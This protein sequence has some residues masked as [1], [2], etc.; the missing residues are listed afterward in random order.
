MNYA[1]TEQLV[2]I[3]F[4]LV[5]MVV[6]V[7]AAY[8]IVP[9]VKDSVIPWLQDRRLYDLIK[10]YVQAAEKMASSNIITKEDKKQFV[11][12]LLASRGVQV[13]AEVSAL[14]ESAVKELDI[15][16]KDGIDAVVD[17]FLDEVNENLDT[18]DVMD[19]EGGD[20]NA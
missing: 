19:D 17:A 16:L 2:S 11:I 4:I 18:D 12:N 6:G 1:I 3:A 14:I 15:A 20:E 5:R 10:K 8:I 13:D 7:I 9:F